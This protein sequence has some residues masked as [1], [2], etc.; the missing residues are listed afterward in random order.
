MIDLQKHMPRI[1]TRFLVAWRYYYLLK[2]WWWFL[3]TRRWV[4]LL[5]GPKYSPSKDLIE[6]DLTYRCNLRCHQCNRSLRHAPSSGSISLSAMVRFVDESLQRPI[7]WRRIRLLGG[8]PTLHPDFFA[9]LDTL[10]KYKDSFPTCHIEVVTNGHGSQVNKILDLLPLWVLV[11]NSVKDSD[12]NPEF[13]PFN[14]APIDNPFFKKADFSNGC[15]VIRDCGQALTPQGYYPCAV[16]GAIDRIV[17]K[18]L[19]LSCLSSPNGNVKKTLSELCRYCG[20]FM[21]GHF[22]PRKLR[23]A[24]NP[25]YLSPTWVRLYSEIKK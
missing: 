17:Q 19:G 12:I 22:I 25:F 3:R 21:D 8:E 6:I 9:L 2:R 15:D 23:Y 20:R 10:R 11:D 13:R 5:M 18:N 1:D 7:P 4:T 16:A 24:F 14:S